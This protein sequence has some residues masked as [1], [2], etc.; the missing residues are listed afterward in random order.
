[1]RA[2]DHQVSDSSRWATRLRTLAAINVSC[3]GKSKNWQGTIPRRLSSTDPMESS[4]KPYPATE[5]QRRQSGGTPFRFRV[6]DALRK[7]PAGKVTTYGLLAK[8]LKTSP[9][10]VGGALRHNPYAP[11][12]PCHRVIAADYFVGGFSGYVEP[13]RATPSASL[14]MGRRKGSCHGAGHGAPERQLTASGRYWRVK[15]S[16]LILK[17]ICQRLPERGKSTGSLRKPVS[18]Q[19][20]LAPLNKGRVKHPPTSICWTRGS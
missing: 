18:I 2:Y 13:I 6:Y 8:H 3:H 14:W 19:V 11:Y 7:I 20:R 9:R 17:V 1:M 10:A 12:I 4:S 16:H 15:G 5:A